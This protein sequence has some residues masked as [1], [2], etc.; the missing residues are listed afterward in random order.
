MVT[1][2]AFALAAAPVADIFSW[3]VGAMFVGTPV[4]SG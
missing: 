4:Q 2:F 3:L 1:S